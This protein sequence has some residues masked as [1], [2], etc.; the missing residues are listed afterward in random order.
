MPRPNQREI[1]E[2]GE[3]LMQRNAV[4]NEAL[5]YWRAGFNVLPLGS[6]KTPIAK[7]KQWRTE[8]QAESYI[9]GRFNRWVGIGIVTG[10]DNLEVLDFDDA[11]LWTQFVETAPQDLLDRLPEVRTPKGGRHLYYK[12]SEIE[13]NQ[14]LA[15]E[16]IGEDEH[17]NDKLKTL[18]ETRGLGGQVCA[19]CSFSVHPS[20][21]F[22]KLVRGDLAKI[23]TITP[24]ERRTLLDLARTFNKYDPPPKP[25]FIP[26]D[27]DLAQLLGEESSS[28]RPGDDFNRRATWE[29]ILEPKPHGWEVAFVSGGTT[30]WR[31]PGKDDRGASATTGYC[32]TEGGLDLLHVFS[33]NAHP[34]DSEKSYTKFAAYALLNHHGDWSM[35]AQDLAGKGYGNDP[36]MTACPGVDSIRERYKKEVPPAEKRKVE[37]TDISDGKLAPDEPEPAEDPRPTESETA[38]ATAQ[39]TATNND[40][41]WPDPIPL[42]SLYA[43]LELPEF[44]IDA[45]DCCPVFHEQ[46]KAVAHWL[47]VPIDLP[48]TVGLAVLASTLQRS[49]SIAIR[50]GAYVPLTLWTMTSCPPGE[51][52]TPVVERFKAPLVEYEGKLRKEAERR[53]AEDKVRRQ[54]AEKRKVTIEKEAEGNPTDA[55]VNELIKINAH[56]AQP[57]ACMPQL[58]VDDAT[59]EALARVLLD[60][61]G[62]IACISDE[63]TFLEI[64]LGRYSGTPNFELYLKGYDGGDCRVNR[65]KEPPIYLPKVF[66]TLGLVIQDIVLR[67]LSKNAAADEKG[68]F[69]RFLISWPRPMVGRRKQIAEA[70]PASTQERWNNLVIRLAQN[71]GEKTLRLSNDALDLLIA[72]EARYEPLLKGELSALRSWC[73]KA[74]PGHT[75]RLAGILHCAKQDEKQVVEAETIRRAV[76]L[77]EYFLAHQKKVQNQSEHRPE[78]DRARAIIRLLLLNNMNEFRLSDLSDLRA[79]RKLDQDE[80]IAAVSQLKNAHYFKVIHSDRRGMKFRLNPKVKTGGFLH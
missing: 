68:F 77:A 62:E 3:E 75:A 38:S 42:D 79:L 39:P 66:L 45:L 27:L 67:E 55:Q 35:A 76:I 1:Y 63:S 78:V 17:G 15:Q 80:R 36:D 72:T 22:Y 24:E 69:P 40:D 23:P 9:D 20:G 46:C 34:F 52:K 57:K 2:L 10:W 59:V 58:L 74:F 28:N 19:P 11:Y 54:L 4:R 61:H 33:S 51:R 44:P 21:K 53:I 49:T 32:Q 25:V 12:C 13:G 7:W 43:N 41:E 6:N 30:H 73:S 48:A 50:P 18:L 47:Q 60:Q 31:R 8:R 71:A 16:K 26:K 56:L 65:S 29:E 5:R 14:K 64:A 70:F 37:I